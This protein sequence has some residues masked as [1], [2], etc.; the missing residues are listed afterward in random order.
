MHKYRVQY[1]GYGANNVVYRQ[2]EIELVLRHDWS[3]NKEEADKVMFLVHEKIRAHFS[4]F[5]ILVI[6]K[7]K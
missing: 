7:I 2:Q 1:N 4:R 5:D 3:R 6:E